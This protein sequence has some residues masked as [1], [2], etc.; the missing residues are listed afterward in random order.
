[1]KCSSKMYER[2]VDDYTKCCLEEGHEGHHDD[3]VLTWD[4]EPYVLA[5]AP[6]VIGTLVPHEELERLRRIERAAANWNDWNKKQPS[7]TGFELAL[8]DAVTGLKGSPHNG[9]DAALVAVEK[10]TES[11]KR[12]A[13]RTDYVNQLQDELAEVKRELKEAHERSRKEWLVRVPLSERVP[14]GD[15]GG[16]VSKSSVAPWKPNEMTIHRK[17]AANYPV[18]NSLEELHVRRWVATVDAL[19]SAL[20]ELSDI[21]HRTGCLGCP[22]VPTERCPD[23]E[24]PHCGNEVGP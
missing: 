3:G 16:W 15:T 19:E 10:A 20:V 5:P 22:M 7:W 11:F 17:N 23:G 2:F 24:C 6:Q 1:M 13:E 18:E 14:V 8:S 12:L 21:K 9:L 4:D